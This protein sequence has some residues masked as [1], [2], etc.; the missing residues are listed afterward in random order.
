LIG[1]FNQTLT[2][3]QDTE[4]G[5]IAGGGDRFTGFQVGLAIPIWFAPHQ[6]RTRAAE[7]S[8]RA[9]ESNYTSTQRT[10]SGDLQQAIQA[11]TKNRNSL[12]YYKE[13]GLPNADLILK[14]SQTAFR[15]GEIGYAEYLLGLRN[16]NS[17]R[18]NYL[19]TLSDYNQSIIFIEFLVGNKSN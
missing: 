18:E 7:F 17:I 5:I 13:T 19:Q 2:G 10:M 1:Y 3:V 12:T 9:A 4:T 15:N 6:A 16:A 8:R 11:Y 14:Q